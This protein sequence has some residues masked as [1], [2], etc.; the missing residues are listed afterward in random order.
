M[1]VCLRRK[2]KLKK[3]I[4][5]DPLK[6]TGSWRCVNIMELDLLMRIRFE[7]IFNLT[8]YPLIDS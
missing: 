3:N 6:S 4:V 8:G 1:A 5:E 7:T 2:T